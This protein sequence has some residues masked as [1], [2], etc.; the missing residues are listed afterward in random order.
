M[1][2][3]TQMASLRSKVERELP[4]D[5][6][7]KLQGEAANLRASGNWRKAR[8]AGE[9]A[10]DI[11]LADRTGGI[12][13][14]SDL[15]V[16]G[17]VIVSFY[18][19]DWCRFCRLH[20]QALAEIAGEVRAL[21][22]SLI[23]VAPK[24]AVAPAVT[25][26]AA[27]PFPLLADVDAKVCKAFGL[28]FLPADDLHDAYTALG[29]PTG[30]ERRLALPVPA[31]YAIDRSSTIVFSYFDSDFTSRLAPCEILAI[32]RR[33]RATE[34]AADSNAFPQT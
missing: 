27:P 5:S 1:S 34:E 8:K 28:T 7:D 31:V 16:G 26:A 30:K 24:I 10:P 9:A 6:F 14:L 23:A 13:R 29:R 33:L 20:L 2:F 4:G 17:P 25:C 11:Q 19:G 22:A 15:L 32:L 18:R 21:G 3:K 12:V